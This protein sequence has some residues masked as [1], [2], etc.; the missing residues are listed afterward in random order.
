VNTVGRSGRDGE[1][2]GRKRVE[3]RAE[4]WRQRLE[5]RTE[6]ELSGIDVGH[7]GGTTRLQLY[8]TEGGE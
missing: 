7:G 2:S 8:S 6:A 4:L 3:P 5:G 1:L